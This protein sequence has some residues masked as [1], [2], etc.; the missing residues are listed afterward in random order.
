[1]TTNTFE[2]LAS[3]SDLQDGVP[4][5]AELADGT[6]ICLIRVGDEVYAV[7]DRCTHAEFSLSDSDMVDDHVIECGLHGAQ[8]DVRTGQVLEL[9]ATERLPCFEVKVEAGDVFVRGQP[10]GTG[11]G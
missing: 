1:M 11:R 4:H 9:P 3:L 2:R 5:A 6:G 10:S 8:F 7:H